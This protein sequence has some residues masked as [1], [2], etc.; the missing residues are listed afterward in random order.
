[1]QEAETGRQEAVIQLQEAIAES[2]ALRTELHRTAQELK[3]TQG[4]LLLRTKRLDWTTNQLQDAEDAAR[5]AAAAA[6]RT[7]LV[8]SAPGLRLWETCCQAVGPHQDR[9]CV[10][11]RPSGASQTAGSNV[12]VWPQT[13]L[14]A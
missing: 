6:A 11:S 3:D 5:S 4:E 10:L 12:S 7:A 8:V 13:T 1:M 14:G 2:T 9:T